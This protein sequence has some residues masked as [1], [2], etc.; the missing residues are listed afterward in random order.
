MRLGGRLVVPAKPY[1]VKRAFRI[2]GKVAAIIA[3]FQPF[4]VVHRSC[5]FS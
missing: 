3:P 5:S 1:G 2:G 4:F